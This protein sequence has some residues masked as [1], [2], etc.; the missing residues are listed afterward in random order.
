MGCLH[1][2][3]AITIGTGRIVKSD[4]DKRQKLRQEA[5]HRLEQLR[6]ERGDL[7]D[8]IVEDYENLIHELQ[9]QQVELQMHNEELRNTQ[10][11][12]ER[13][14]EQFK[15]LYEFAPVGYLV[16]DEK[17]NIL[18]VNLK[19]VRL[20]GK[21]RNELVG[22]RLYDLVEMQNRDSLY[23]H[24][25]EIRKSISGASTELELIT[26]R[27]DRTFF[28]LQSQIQGAEKSDRGLVRVALTD[29]SE[30]KSAEQKLRESEQRL[31][32]ATQGAELGVFEWNP[33][34]DRP[35]WSNREMYRIFG[36]EPGAE[37]VTLQE[38]QKRYLHRDD[39]AALEAALEGALKEQSL[40]HARVRIRRKREKA[41]RWIEY[42]GQYVAD[43]LGDPPKLYGV[44]RDVTDRIEA[45]EQL[46]K[47]KQELEQLVQAKDRIVSIIGHDIRNA[48]TSNIHTSQLLMMLL[49]NEEYGKME[50]FLTML[51]ANSRNLV[52][53]LTNLVEW[54]RMELGDVTYQPEPI[55]LQS[56]VA[57]LYDLYEG[58]LQQRSIGL[59][60]DLPDGLTL[61]ADKNM[62]KTILRNLIANAIKFSNDNSEIIIS[63][64]ETDDRAHISV[65]DFGYGISKENLNTIFSGTIADETEEIENRKGT[66]LGLI[67]VQEF[68]HRHNGDVWVES[69]RN[70]GA[71]FHFTMP[72][73]E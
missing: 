13:S 48:L 46:R 19:A 1:S 45:E 10:Q 4:K 32:I 57:E 59:V 41:W 38:L 69:E 68:V 42:F 50:R 53:L 29:I 3:G 28:L 6:K 64:K 33:G 34:N 7:P 16:I 65:R 62:L 30:Q 56:V 63:A 27:A 71:H 54:A 21:D 24:L 15:E 58:I 22:S 52:G 2:G 73:A 26:G 60:T 66:G 44:V 35:I 61:H 12:L 39:S 47:S 43:N 70:N 17:T 55:A 31:R 36:L 5:K 9:V 72:L 8:H 49:K 67:L 37:P 51:G 20:L 14:Q 11:A 25:M 23:L 40:F 18:R